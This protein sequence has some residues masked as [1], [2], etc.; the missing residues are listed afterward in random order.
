MTSKSG[1]SVY[2]SASPKS[3]I[4]GLFWTPLQP[5]STL[6]VSGRVK[7]YYGATL[8]QL[9][10]CINEIYNYCIAHNSTRSV[11]IPSKDSAAQPAAVV[12][13][14]LASRAPAGSRSCSSP[15]GSVRGERANFTRLV[16]S[17]I[18]AKCCKK[19]SVG[20]LSPRSTQCT[21]LHRSQCSKFCSKIAAK[22]IFTNFLAIFC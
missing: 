2:E 12:R 20:K 18:E 14:P 16:I 17:C 10:S 1:V 3:D 11:W 15:G 22:L 5:C 21:P 9:L 19:I 8:K 4:A 13:H 7:H 6:S